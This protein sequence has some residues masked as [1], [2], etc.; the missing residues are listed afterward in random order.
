M[1]TLTSLLARLFLNVYA[2]LSRQGVR[3]FDETINLRQR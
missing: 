1:T 2:I 3:V